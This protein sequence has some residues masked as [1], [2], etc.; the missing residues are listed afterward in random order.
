MCNNNN[1]YKRVCSCA[2]RRNA[3]RNQRNIINGEMARIKL[4]HQRSRNRKRESISMAGVA[5]HQLR[6][7]II[8]SACQ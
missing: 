7:S 5:W 6:G 8:I 3:W 4:Q 2:P 1:I